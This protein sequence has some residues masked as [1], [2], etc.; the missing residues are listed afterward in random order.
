MKALYEHGF[1]VP[2]AIDNNRHA[3][4]MT[5]VDARPLV[6]L[7]QLARPARAYLS[8]MELISRLAGKG[9]VH[10]DF[11]EFNLLINDQSEDLTLIDFPQMVS[12]THANARELFDRDVA[13]IVRFFSKKLGYV[14]ERDPALPYVRPSFD[15]AVAAGRAED[16]AA[17]AEGVPGAGARGGAVSLD[18]ELEASGFKRQY[19]AV[20]EEVF[21]AERQQEE[22]G[23][24]G[25]EPEQGGER[26]E[27]WAASG[28][29][30]SSSEEGEEEE[31]E[32]QGPAAGASEGEVEGEGRGTGK[33]GRRANGSAAAAGACASG[34]E[35]EGGEGSDDEEASSSGGDDEEGSL[36]GGPRSKGQRRMTAAAI[37][38]AAAG[39]GAKPHR[40]K[41]HDV[42]HIYTEERKKQKQRQAL[43]RA[44]SSRNASKIKGRGKAAAVSDG[45]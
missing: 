45:W 1:P 34:S 29:G 38:A 14:P 25:E 33:G 32:G 19:Q 12:V 30:D 24:E 31:E 44:T 39:G 40:L 4:L 11:N 9:L 43:A 18:V 37:S 2:Q 7:R 42:Q 13:C 23:G 27:E 16:A 15:D 28:S 10:C 21:A 5:L 41:A 20:L 8:A 35:G 36:A 22:E 17:A 3:V 6:Q 26:Q